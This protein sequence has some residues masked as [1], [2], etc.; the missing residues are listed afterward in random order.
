M[1]GMFRLFS[2]HA[3]AETG[4]AD[5]RI[6]GRLHAPEGFAALSL[7]PMTLDDLDEWSEVRRFND[8]WLKPW[9]SGDPMNGPTITFNEWV[10]RQ[11]RAEQSGR[12]AVMLMIAD[13]RIVGQIS[14]GAI[15]YG[16]MRT[17]T[18]GYWVDRRCVGHGYAPIALA[19]LADWALLDETGPM[20]HSIEVAILPENARSRRVVEK[21]GLVYEGVRRSYMYVNGQWRDHDIYTLVSSD[22]HGRVID[23]LRAGA[24]T[25][26][27]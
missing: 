17:G 3:P 5:F 8:D 23:R 6:P 14:L 12:G 19:L 7:R 4:N 24:P 15:C 16:A 22:V 13:G 10:N 1:R 2:K 11:R 9:D 27:P 20:L 26:A 21:L 18:I 25:P